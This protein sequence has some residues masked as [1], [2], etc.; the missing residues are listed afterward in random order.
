MAIYLI[1]EATL[2]LGPVECAVVPG[3]GIQLPG[4]A[5]ELEA[6]LP[7]PAPGKVWVWRNDSAQQVPDQRGT[8]YHTENGAK[9]EW[10][11]PGE[12][13]SVYTRITWPGPYHVWQ[14]DHWQLDAQAKTAAETQQALAVVDELLGKAAIRIAPLEDAVELD[15]ATAQEK[16]ALLQWKGYRVD[17]NRIEDQ[18]GFPSDIHWPAPPET[19]H[20]R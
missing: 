7:D 3:M 16:A 5:R 6:E 13:P 1:E 12:L 19:R 14:N 4:N 17:L 8:V 20:S 11:L 10:T 15:R 9:L 18:E 2:M